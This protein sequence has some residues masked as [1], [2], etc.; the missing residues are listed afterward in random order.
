MDYLF[1][2]ITGLTSHNRPVTGLQFSSDGLRLVSCGLDNKARIWCTQTGRN[3][4]L[5]ISVPSSGTRTSQFAISQGSSP[6]LIF[7]PNGKCIEA[8]DINTGKSQYTLHGHFRQVTCC[9]YHADFQELYSGSGDRNIL[10]WE[11]KTGTSSNYVCKSNVKNVT[12]EPESELTV[13]DIEHV[14]AISATAD[15][16]S[17][18]E[19]T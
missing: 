15:S 5:D 18:D 4:N 1:F 19:E 12:R 16:W 2:L 8:Y 17:S 10:V 6:D 14:T 3:L 9:Y 11:A 7:M 13:T